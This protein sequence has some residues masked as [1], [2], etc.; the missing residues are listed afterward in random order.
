MDIYS[1]GVF[2]SRGEGLVTSLALQSHPQLLG[3]VHTF[4]K[5]VGMLS[6]MYIVNQYVA[7][8]F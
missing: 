5:A 2:G 8:F 4:G 6:C 1:T 3:T 7:I